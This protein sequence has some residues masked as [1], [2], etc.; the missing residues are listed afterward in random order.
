MSDQ[1]TT[2]PSTDLVTLFG[3]T[4]SPA[5]QIMLNDA[6]FRRCRE[7]AD[8]MARAE[9]VT[10]QHLINKKEACFSVVSMALIWKLAPMMVAASTFQLPGSNKLGYEA[11]LVQAILENSGQFV[12]QIK[13]EYFGEWDRVLGKFTIETSQKGNKYAKAAWTPKDEEGLGVIVT[14]QVKGEV[15][16]RTFRFLLKQAFPRNSTIWATDPMTQLWYTAVRRFGS[17]AAPGIMMGVPFDRDELSFEDGLVDVT[18]AEAQ[19]KP[20]A[21]HPRDRD[22]AR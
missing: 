19:P 12:G 10:P 3:A 22:R 4:Q 17:V 20:P 14:G 8:I 1:S 18:P 15:E 13:S 6:L 9:G 5:L 11:K 16:P 7:V 21:A 2:L